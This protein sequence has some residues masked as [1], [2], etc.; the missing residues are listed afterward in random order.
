M[1]V[2]LLLTKFRQLVS[3]PVRFLP[4][5]RLRFACV[6]SYGLYIPNLT[7]PWTSHFLTLAH[8]SLPILQEILQ[9][10]L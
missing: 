9:M 4:N 1:H 10:K 6:V 7:I 2:I 3:I 5:L 8:K